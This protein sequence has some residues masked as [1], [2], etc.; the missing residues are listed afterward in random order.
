MSAKECA[1]IRTSHR[2]L[3]TFFELQIWA[4]AKICEHLNVTI[5]GKLGVY[6]RFGQTYIGMLC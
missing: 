5:F 2:Y 3:H 1:P 4:Q 6:H